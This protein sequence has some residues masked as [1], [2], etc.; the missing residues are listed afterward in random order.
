MGRAAVFFAVFFSFSAWADQPYRGGAIATAHPLA[1]EAAR[2]ILD[3]G[4]NA[5]DA[6]VA[7]AFVL[8]VVAPYHSGLGG[9]GFALTWDAKGKSAAVLDFREVAPASAT[10][11][12][13]L[14][15]GK[16]VPL[17]STDGPRS[18][19]VP[20]AVK[21]YLELLEKRGKLK[22]AQVMAPALRLAREGF[23]V[24]PKFR[25]L[26]DSREACLRTDPVTTKLF[27]EA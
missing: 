8:A 1:S 22:R 14:D 16:V 24:T 10:R 15:G 11:D 7:A 5:V 26:A 12:M 6:A 17:A 27:M 2:D 3:K 9:G 19:A 20:G 4:G 23:V 21:G 25:Q 13:F 18:V